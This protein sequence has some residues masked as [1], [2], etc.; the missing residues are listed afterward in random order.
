MA[1]SGLSYSRGYI[2]NVKYTILYIIY[3]LKRHIHLSKTNTVEEV[4]TKLNII[5][6]FKWSRICIQ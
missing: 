2:L 4:I 3:F 6:H 1:Q 5:K